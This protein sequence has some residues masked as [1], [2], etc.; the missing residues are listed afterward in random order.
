MM[1]PFMAVAAAVRRPS[2]TREKRSPVRPNRVKQLWRDGAP[3][4]VNWLLSGN[5]FLAEV[6]AHAGADAILIDMQHG[7]G[8]TPAQV[9][10]CLQ[11][12]NTTD[13]VPFVRVPWND[14]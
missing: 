14:P 2:P 9:V 10:S 6:L 12:I 3:V 1:P 5:P 4:A 8:L 7:P 13:T 11:A